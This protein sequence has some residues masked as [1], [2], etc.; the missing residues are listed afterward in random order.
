VDPVGGVAWHDVLVD[1]V[2]GDPAVWRVPQ[3]GAVADGEVPETAWQLAQLLVKPA[4]FTVVW[5]VARY[6]TAW[7]APP[8]HGTLVCWTEWQ[9]TVHVWFVAL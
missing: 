5:A 8:S 7:F 6:G 1:A 2:S 9:F 3:V 4:E